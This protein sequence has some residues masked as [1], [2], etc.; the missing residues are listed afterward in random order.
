MGDRA[1]A[2][3]ID[4]SR[5]ARSALRDRLGRQAVV[6]VDRVTGTA[7]SIQRLDGALTG[8][9]AGDRADVARRWL[10]ANHEALGLT[11]ADVDALRVSDRVT[12]PNGLTHL[13]FQQSVA[14]IPAFDNGVRVALDRGG[15]ILSVSGSP[16]RAPRLETATPRLSAV[17]AM[18]ALQQNVGVKRAI[19]VVRGPA[20]VRQQTWFPHDDF[21]RL[22]LFG[23]ANGARLAWHLTYQATSTAYYDAVVDATSGDVLYRQNLTK[24]AEDVTVF[25][26]YPG[27]QNETAPPGKDINNAPRTVDLEPWLDSGTAELKGPFAHTYS[28]ENDNNVADPGETIQ[29]RVPE[30]DFDW[31]FTDFG[32]PTP[33]FEDACEFDGVGPDDWP[34]PI[35]QTADCSWDP[36]DRDSWRTNRAQSGVAAFYLT[37]AF[38]DHLA[39]APIGFDAASGAFEVDDYVRVENNDGANTDGSGGPDGEHI[40]NANMSTPPDGLRPRMQNYLFEFDPDPERFFNFR[41]I[42]GGDDAA[43]VWH[44]YTHGLSN[45]LVTNADGSGATSSPHTGAMGE[46]WSD[47]YAEDLLHR[48]GLEIDTPAAGE[49]DIGVYSDA[50]FTSTRFTPMDCG[51]GDGALLECPGGIGGAGFG[52]YTFGDFGKVFVGPEV[53]S[54]GEIWAQTLWDLRTALIAE[55]GDP[56][57]GSDYAEML[58]TEGMRLSP[59]EPSFLDMR[60]AILAA[61]TAAGGTHRDL[62]WDVFAGRGMGFYASVTGS[63]DTTAIENFDLPPDPNASTG[64]ISGKVTTAASG[65]A[66]GGV[67]VGIGGLVTAPGFSAT[68]AA[69]GTYTLTVPA[70]TYSELVFRSSDGYDTFVVANLAVAG[71]QTT[72]A[73]A[74]LERDWA[75]SAGG[76]TFTGSDDTGADFGCGVAKVVD[77]ESGTGWSP[78]NPASTDAENPHAGPP[79]ATIT[80]PQRIDVASFGMDPAN[81][82]GDDPSATTKDYRVETSTDGQSFQVAKAGAF[83]MADR[84]KLNTVTPTANSKNIKAVRLTLLSPQ[85]TNGS[86]ADFIDFSEFAVYGNAIPQGTLS[87]TPTSINAGAT[88]GFD[89]ASFVDPDGSV[90]GYDW[91]FDGDGN[92]DR[93]TDGATTD[94][95]YGSGGT[96]N[97]RV[98]V[99]DNGGSTGEASATITVAAAPPPPPPAA[100]PVPPGSYRLP[101]ALPKLTLP[102]T[103]TRGQVRF[104]V[105]CYARCTL[106]GKLVLSKATARKLRL[107]RRTIGTFRRTIT[108][109]TAT[110]RITLRITKRLRTIARRR[111]LK[112][113][114]VQLSVKAAY[115]DRRSKSAKRNVRVRL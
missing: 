73:N 74:A 95:A 77:Q 29:R 87:A 97:A 34:P 1:P 88:V 35:G 17:D 65:L 70:S 7:R 107:K 57:L 26:N 40:N 62:V 91:D 13:R 113:L 84:G 11:A 67:R 89:A 69:D 24:F 103:G 25:P 41:N 32:E 86:G 108:R 101:V 78:F 63:S 60:N 64:T 36:T 42:N 80:L 6:D 31:P 102:R 10:S 49:V 115:A 76:A 44:E 59:P 27:A 51:P 56:I 75:A 48:E 68:T 53:H 21:A 66:L 72:V 37:N 109:T 46:A 85:S 15:R 3:A 16:L 82:C 12:T 54:D 22:V 28:D 112:T 38:H 52:G 9:A 98:R 23:T 8:P 105:R 30:N 50:V 55:L 61:E 2:A 114:T 104:S 20:G 111:K 4:R 47:W 92:T 90:I 19:D 45:R 43:T 93:S 110:Q 58:V 79:T 5:N 71:G 39:G 100:A 83:A 14:G 33:A 96:F 81:T 99:R 18:R 94:F 106:T